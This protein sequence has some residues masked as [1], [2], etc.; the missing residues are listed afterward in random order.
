[1]CLKACHGRCGDQKTKPN[2]FHGIP[3][4]IQPALFGKHQ[5][6]VLLA[7]SISV[8]FASGFSVF[9]GQIRRIATALSAKRLVTMLRVANGDNQGCGK[10]GASLD[11][12][13]VGR[14]Q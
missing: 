5:L 13:G 6:T 1:M 9:S 8:G 2:E 3:P 7:F 4:P 12:N 11:G 10:P 14:R